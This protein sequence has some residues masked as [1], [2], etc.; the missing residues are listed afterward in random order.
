M[1]VRFSAIAAASSLVACPFLAQARQPWIDAEQQAM[2]QHYDDLV[3]QQS[4]PG[5]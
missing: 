4:A 1:I 2:I 3:E 5:Q